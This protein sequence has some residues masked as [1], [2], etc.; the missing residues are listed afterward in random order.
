MDYR[1][2]WPT[3][4]EA[5]EITEAQR[6]SILAIAERFGFTNNI[7]IVPEFGYHPNKGAVFLCTDSMVYGIEPDGYAHT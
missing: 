5:T 6:T 1:I 7:V 4:K 3:W 2:F